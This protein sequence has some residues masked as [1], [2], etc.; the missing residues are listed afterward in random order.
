[1]SAPAAGESFVL[2]RYRDI[3][4]LNSILGVLYWDMESHMPPNSTDLRGRQIGLLSSLIHERQSDPAFVKAALELKDSKYAPPLRREILN[5]ICVDADFVEKQSQAQ[6]HCQARWKDA[7]KAKEF[8]L[9]RSELQGLV[10]LQREWARRYKANPL[11]QAGSLSAFE[12]HFDSYE[13]GF[14]QTRLQAL[15]DKLGPELSRRVKEIVQKRSHRPT[16]TPAE[17]SMPELEQQALCHRVAQD[18]GFDF[19]RGRIDK[20]AHPFCGGHSED[21]RITTRYQESDFTNA[22]SS[23]MHEGGHALYEQGIPSELFHTPIGVAASLGVHESQSRFMENQIGRSRAF[24]EY[25]GRITNRSPETLFSHL[26]QVKTSLIRVDAD[27]VTYN[28]HILVRFDLERRLING[29]IEVADLPRLWNE[30]YKKLL[31]LDVPHD[32]DG[33]LQDV[34]WYGGAFGYFAT[35]TLGNLIAAALFADF[36][37]QHPNWETLVSQGEFGFVKDFLRNR[38]HRH[39]ALHDSPTTIRLA[40]GGQDLSVEPFLH[41]IDQKY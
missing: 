25:L 26:N 33:V 31:N 1:M 22:L 9:V 17:L 6:V 27:E 8:S 19:K 10:D 7:R 11:A 36:Q 28:L 38:V 15:L 4:H 3:S 29:E 41:Y 13:P 14:G 35:Y 39:A 30:G 5:K 34:H 20:S 23:I 24:C 21:T 37:K 16:G 32:G 18:I 2:E 40:L 12:I